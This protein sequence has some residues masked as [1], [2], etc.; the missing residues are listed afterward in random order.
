MDDIEPLL[1]LTIAVLQQQLEPNDFSGKA[2]LADGVHALKRLV[3]NE[4]PN[5]TVAGSWV[6]WVIP[7]FALTVREKAHFH[8]PAD[9]Y[10]E[11]LRD[12]LDAT[13]G[14]SAVGDRIA[15][16]RYVDENS[17]D[18]D[19]DMLDGVYDGFINNLRL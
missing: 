13:I 9:R 7:I 19:L 10:V 2:R 11:E 1:T 14:L 16:A 18:P 12:Y 8:I 15:H 6:K 4:A 3:R 5:Q 17:L